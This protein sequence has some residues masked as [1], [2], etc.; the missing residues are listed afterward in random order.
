VGG[1]GLA[2][3]GDVRRKGR[4]VVFC[5]IAWA[6]AFSGFAFS[7][8]FPAALASLA[9]VGVFQVGVS[10]TTITLLQTRVP[11][12]MSGRVMSLNTLLIMGVRPLGDFAAAAAIA[13]VGG[14]AATVA[15]AAIVGV[16][17][18]VVAGR[19]SVLA[20]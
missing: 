16:V 19:R 9:L 3:A 6:V 11:R 10:A 2:S 8:S 5:A 1:V 4:V 18:L 12:S 7:R 17:A 15:C 20:A 14:L 13:R